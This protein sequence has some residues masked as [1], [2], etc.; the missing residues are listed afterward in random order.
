MKWFLI[1]WAGPI[2]F[3]LAWYGLSSYNINFGTFFFS[4]QMHDLVFEI[5]GRILGIPPQDIP[6]LVFKA[7][8]FDT[9]V[10]LGLLVLRKRRELLQWWQGRHN[11]AQEEMGAD[12]VE[13]LS[14]AP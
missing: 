12:K 10:V 3:L 5:Y 14:S 7:M 6:P 13:S 2:G 8:L 9:C 4:R 11:P 1:L